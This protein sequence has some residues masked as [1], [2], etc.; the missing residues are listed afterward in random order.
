MVNIHP[1]SLHTLESNHKTPLFVL[2]N[3]RSKYG[4]HK[5]SA[6]CYVQIAN[7]TQI[8]NFEKLGQ[9]QPAIVSLIAFYIQMAAWIFLE[10]F[11]ASH[12][13]ELHDRVISS[14]LMTFQ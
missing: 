4:K 12:L 10:I 3:N 1:P 13:D 14:L 7:K 8:A 11:Y 6:N 5:T 2:E 9:D